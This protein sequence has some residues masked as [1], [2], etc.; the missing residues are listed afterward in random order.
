[1]QIDSNTSLRALMQIAKDAI[2]ELHDDEE[3]IVKDL[4]K[5]FE[6]NRIDKVN[7]SRLGAL[8]FNFSKNDVELIII[9]TGKTH[10][11]QQKYKK[12]QEED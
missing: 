11:N 4:F 9:G 1:M 6:W 7:K 5:G 8:F 12:L 3:F 10:Q 2:N